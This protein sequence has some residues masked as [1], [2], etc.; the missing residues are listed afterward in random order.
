MPMGTVVVGSTVPIQ[1]PG[2]QIGPRL[3]MN[4]G[5]TGIA[6]LRLQERDVRGMGMGLVFRSH[7]PA[8]CWVPQLGAEFLESLIGRHSEGHYT[9]TPAQNLG[10]HFQ[11]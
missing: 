9:T 7:T 2:L 3:Q 11:I 5:R 1:E 10:G 8:H 4:E 6:G